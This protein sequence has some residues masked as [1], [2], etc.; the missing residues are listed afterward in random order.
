MTASI[1]VIG[2]DIAK[3]RQKAKITLL[4]LLIEFLSLRR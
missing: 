1:K 4:K 3:G 2:F